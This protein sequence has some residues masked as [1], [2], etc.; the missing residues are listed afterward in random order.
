MEKLKIAVIGSGIS[1]LSAAWLLSS[2]HQVTLYEAGSH[3]G[4]HANTVDVET[5][6]G[7]VAVDTGFIVYN[8][9]NYP[10]LVELFK[11]LNVETNETI[12]NFAL[13][14]DNGAYEYSSGGINGFFGQRRNVGRRRHWRLLMDLSRFFRNVLTEI[15]QHPHAIT[16][17]TFL[18]REGYSDV[19][20]EDHI[21]P[22]GAAI[23]STDMNEML[24]F[25]ARSFIQFY[26]N[27]GLLKFWG[28]PIWSTVTGGSR[29]YVERLIE[30]GDFERHKQNRATRVVRHANYVHITDER[31]TDR[32]FDH[33]VIATHADH[34]LALLDEPDA[35]ETNLLNS[36]PYQE[37]KAILHRDP[38]W[39]PQRRRLWSSWNYLKR[40]DAGDSKLCVSYWMNELQ[41]LN[42]KTDLFVTLNPFDEIHPKTIDGEF[43]YDHP[44]FDANALEAQKNL[45]EIQ[46]TKR[47]WFCGSYFGHG[48]HED[49][50]QSGLAVAEQLGGVQRPWKVDNPSGR[51]ASISRPK[52][53][54]AAE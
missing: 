15:E 40:G 43:T 16:L 42:T 1:G 50:I 22:M 33:V 27:H 23:W 21:V 14:L 41:T 18:Q 46:G 37:N 7:P 51:I 19:F 13:S 36:F 3:F 25:P 29:N 32:P 30:D 35:L 2:K 47:T 38:R 54:E 11:H 8:Q 20:V 10:N 5:P 17:G 44:V 4:G 48:F 39:M 26:A 52:K 53:I 12:M 9:G 6:D 45:W 31:G 24:D 28:Q 34:A 49:G